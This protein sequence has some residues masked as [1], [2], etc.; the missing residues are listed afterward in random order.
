MS[1]NTQGPEDGAEEL[2]VEQSRMEHEHTA[3]M[4]YLRD[5]KSVV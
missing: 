5:R 3:D 4:S 1:E 2:A